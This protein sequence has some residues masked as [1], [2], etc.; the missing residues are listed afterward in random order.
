[1]SSFINYL[2][3]LLNVGSS[4]LS[5]VLG[6]KAS[7][8]AAKTQSAATTRAANLL[9]QQEQQALALQNQ[10]YQQG[11]TVQSPYAQTGYAA[12]RM[13]SELLGF[14]PPAPTTY[15]AAGVP[16][17][18]AGT[19][20]GGAFPSTGIDLTASGLA[21]GATGPSTGQK[22]LGG[23]L[24]GA[25]IATTGAA[26]GGLLGL[27]SLAGP[28]GL[29]AGGLAAG[30]PALINAASGPSSYQAGSKEA[31]RDFGVNIS[32]DQIKALFGDLGFD[33][34]E[35][36][37]IRKELESSP[38]SLVA[39]GQIAQNQGTLPQFLQ[40]IGKVQTSWGNQDFNEAYE[41]G[42]ATGD[43]S[44]LNEAYNQ[45]FGQSQALQA[46]NPDWQKALDIQG[47]NQGA[48]PGLPS[49]LSTSSQRLEALRSGALTKGANNQWV[50]TDP[51]T[52]QATP[53]QQEVAA[54]AGLT[55]SG[56]GGTGTTG[57]QDGTGVY[58]PYAG[59]NA[60][61]PQSMMGSLLDISGYK[62]P[63]QEEIMAQMDPSLQ[64]QLGQGREAIEASA[65]AQGTLM[66]GGT[67]KALEQYAQGLGSTYYQQARQ[68]AY[69][70]ALD[71]YNSQVQAKQNLYNNLMGLSGSGQTAANQITGAAGQYGANVGNL[72]M[73]TAGNIGNLWTS[74]AAAEAGGQVGS[75]NAWMNAANNIAN[76]VGGYINLRTGLNQGGDEGDGGG[77]N[78]QV[79]YTAPIAQQRG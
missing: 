66:S 22:V 42:M 63:T 58:N 3:P 9:F 28:L 55:G 33:E 25:G 41:Y 15:G 53:L 62:A 37:N 39:L 59:I 27:G 45:G 31:L 19:G 51:A 68:N 40:A 54:S 20:G 5:G 21:Q 60:D 1:M 72:M 17:A 24:G 38:Q 32:D 44:P 67:A 23:V 65:A 74:G 79:L 64:F 2:G 12:N 8:S 49:N 34:G 11:L 18:V 6:S 69:Q 71:Q 7:T 56:A 35:A 75:A 30:I 46:A 16:G 4:M 13:L 36:W 47:T 70:S 76:T 57:T 73:G 10:A 14:T 78:P 77:N 50:Y 48:I 43:W 61:V 52:G 29:A 26:L